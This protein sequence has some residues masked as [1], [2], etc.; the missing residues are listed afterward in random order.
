MCDQ[1]VDG[2]IGTICGGSWRRRRH[3]RFNVDR[4]WGVPVKAQLLSASTTVP[5]SQGRAG[6]IKSTTSATSRLRR[7]MH[8]S[9]VIQGSTAPPRVGAAIRPPTAGDYKRTEVSAHLL[10][11]VSA[12]FWSSVLSPPGVRAGTPVNDDT[13]VSAT[14]KSR[15]HCRGVATRA[16]YRGGGHLRNVDQVSRRISRHRVHAQP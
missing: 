12:G 14:A 13:T 3:Q 10:S 1:G 5:S 9:A 16:N 2:I 7:G 4:E 6:A 8:F 15:A 11:G